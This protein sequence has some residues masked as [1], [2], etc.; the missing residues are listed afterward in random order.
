MCILSFQSRV[1][2]CGRWLGLSPCSAY[3]L[4]P[5]IWV[6]LFLVRLTFICTIRKL[7]TN[8]YANF[9]T[10]FILAVFFDAHMPLSN[11]WE[12]GQWSFLLWSCVLAYLAYAR[13]S[14]CLI[15][16][17][18]YAFS[19]VQDAITCKPISRITLPLDETDHRCIGRMLIFDWQWFKMQ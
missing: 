14:T 9:E 4:L 6:R 12:P 1:M 8:D 2:H 17:W 16:S 13:V 11:A 15:L 3:N 7:K 19:I 10:R 18:Y 5:K